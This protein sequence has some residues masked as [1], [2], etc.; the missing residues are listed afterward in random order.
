MNNLPL[1]ILFAAL[2]GLLVMS[3][4]F[5]GSET[6]LMSLNR[7]RLRH[8]TKK[9]H[10][11]AHKVTE[12]LRRPDRLLG[13]VLIGNNL[14]NV[15]ATTITTII[16]MRLY[17]DAG[18]AI[19]SALLTLVILIFGE[20][21]PKTVAAQHPER[22]AF[23]ASWILKPMAVIMHPLVIMINAVSNS[24]VRIFGVRTQHSTLEHLD[25][26]ELRTV[27]DEAGD[28]I[29][30][31][32]QGMLLN[33]LDLEKSTVEDIMIPRNEVEGLDLERPVV[34]LLQQIRTSD[35]TRLPLYEGDINNVVGLLHLRDA[36]R[37][38]AKD[39]K[40]ITVE[41]ILSFASEPYFVPEATPLTTQL[42]N[43]QQ[44]KCRMALVVDEYGEV[45]GIV[46]L[47]DLLEEIV[48]EFTTN[49]AEQADQDI[50][51]T[52]D[53]GYLIDGGTFVRDINRHL[54]WELPT[55]GPKTLNGLAMEYLESI[56]DGNVCFE[57]D[58]YRLETTE[59]T[60]KMI[61]WVKVHQAESEEE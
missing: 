1:E 60:D 52:D 19:G 2:V 44:Q 28:L 6:A 10:R 8:L 31:Q 59:I 21:T 23:F 34:D 18:I 58:S 16:A 38:M 14:V 55:R 15:Y 56:P 24:L 49:V 53:G 35:Y 37:F 22:I 26:E 54:D 32:H 42:L 51:A 36:A 7:Y 13:L 43:F 5:S 27:V 3:A 11:S 20:V 30:D 17:G 9:G 46:T 45:Q 47:E 33:V 61:A 41:E 4:F 12:L 29:P 40:D 57:L 25:P 48:G 50:V 39:D